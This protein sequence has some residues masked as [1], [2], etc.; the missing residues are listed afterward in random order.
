MSFMKGFTGTI[1]YIICRVQCKMK[2]GGGLIRTAGKVLWKVVKYEAFF[3][4]SGVSLNL[5]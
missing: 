2:R 4:S 1:S 5:S 3:L